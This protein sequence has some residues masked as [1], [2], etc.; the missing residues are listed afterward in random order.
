MHFRALNRVFEPVVG[1]S[2]GAAASLLEVLYILGQMV[3]YILGQM[4]SLVPRES[5]GT[6]M[7]GWLVFREEIAVLPGRHRPVQCK[8]GFWIVHH[9]RADT[10]LDEAAPWRCT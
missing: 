4:A 2:E 1:V 7:S 9:Y 6:T 8:H 5:V 10:H 3:L